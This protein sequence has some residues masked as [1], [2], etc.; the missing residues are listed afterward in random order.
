MR[1]WRCGCGEAADT[2]VEPGA[3]GGPTGVGSGDEREVEGLAGGAGD[4]PGIEPSDPTGAD[5]AVAGA[6][7]DN[8]TGWTG[9]GRA[10]ASGPGA[11]RPVP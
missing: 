3:A 8:W 9:P 5:V 1:V 7:A 10:E 4:S 11:V 6:S 2:G